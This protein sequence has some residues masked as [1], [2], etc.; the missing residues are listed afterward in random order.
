MEYC[1]NVPKIVHRDIKPDNILV[2][3]TGDDVQVKLGDFGVSLLLPADGSEIVNNNAGSDKFFSPEA[4]MS[5]TYKGKL[6]DLWACGVTL[7]MMV[8]GEF[9]FNGTH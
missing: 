9:P 2:G 6:N 3:G 5:S 8:T 4:C 7:Y 1:H